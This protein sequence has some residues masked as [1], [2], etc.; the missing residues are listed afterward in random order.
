MDFFEK[1]RN[2]LNNEM[3]VSRTENNALG[4]RTSGKN[5]VDLNF[6]V[7]SLRA[8]SENDLAGRYMKAYF[9]DR[10][11]ALLWLFY[12]RDI[13]GGL[14]ERRLFRMILSYLAIHHGELPFKKLIPLVPEYGRFDDL[15]CLMGT[16]QQNLVL[17]FFK[18][19]LARDRAAM[20]TGSSVSLL[21]KWLPSVNA[22]SAAAKLEAR[23][24]A[25]HLGMTEKQYRTTLSALR[26]YLDV[27]EQKM[28][29]KAFGEIHYGTVPSRANVIYRK[30]FLRHDEERRKAFLE[31]LK[32]GEEKINAGAVFPHEIVHA[33]MN[34]RFSPAAY[35]ESLEQLWK[36]LPSPAQDMGNTIVVADGS[37]SMSVKA[38]TGSCSALSV[39]N[40]LA[41]YFAERCGG[42]F[43]NRY[44]TFSS[45]PQLVDLGKVKNLKEKLEI[46]RTHN[47]VSNTNIEAVFELILTTALKD[48]MPQ[49][50]LPKNIVIISDME[51]DACA[52]NADAHLFKQ[53][54][55]KYE[56]NGY[57]LPRLVFWN[58]NSRTNTIPVQENRQ[59]VALVSGFSIYI[60]NMVLSAKLD[61][62]ECL[63]DIL[64]DERYAPAAEVIAALE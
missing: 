47:E 19:Q 42:P 63:L 59:G 26:K 40:G 56:T 9:D 44:I 64:E 17:D 54:Q 43:A 39:A 61:P 10:R 4:S 28:S 38:G 31:S 3:N 29:R 2:T 16:K 51:F 30:A 5:L 57:R 60:L 62:Y 7:P 35:D 34:S 8:A 6:A 1:L 55:K 48:R 23:I 32:N 13:R 11:A 20:E 22:S 15:L 24:I 50:T 53:I 14:G 36:A 52:E 37:G 49:G 58:V 41:I 45:R 21:A 12:A 18:E 33:Y 25:K 27:V 46:A